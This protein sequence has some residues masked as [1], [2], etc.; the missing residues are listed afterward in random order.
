MRSSCSESAKNMQ[1]PSPWLSD[2]AKPFSNAVLF[3]A[4]DS[5]VLLDSVRASRRICWSARKI[6]SP[7]NG[8]GKRQFNRTWWTGLQV[9]TADNINLPWFQN[10]KITPLGYK[11]KLW[12]VLF[13][14]TNNYITSPRSFCNIVFTVILWNGILL[15]LFNTCK[16]K[17]TLNYRKN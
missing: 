2:I 17:K 7:V 1:F 14:K 11:N 15:G 5:S 6:A 16:I 4:C 3:K 9:K 13:E 10:N 8:R 12:V